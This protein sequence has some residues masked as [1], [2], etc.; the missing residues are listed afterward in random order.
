MPPA[1]QAHGF[2]ASPPAKA[3]QDIY[4]GLTVENVLKGN[5][6]NLARY[7][8]ARKREQVEQFTPTGLPVTTIING[9][10]QTTYYGSPIAIHGANG[11]TATGQAAFILPAYDSVSNRD[12]LDYQ[13]DYTFPKRIAV[14][15]GFQYESERGRL[16][17]SATSSN[18]II[19]RS[20]YL[21]TLQ[22]QCDVKH[23]LFYSACGAL[24]NNELYG[25][26]GQPRLGL[27]YDAV[28][29]G[30]HIFR[31]TLLRASAATGVQEPSTIA[32]LTSLYTRLQQTGNSA[33]I[34]LYK[35][36]PITAERSRTY[37]VGIDQ[38]IITQKLTLKAGYFHGQF[39]HQ[40]EFIGANGLNYFNILPP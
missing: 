15:F 40:L 39:S 26:A 4:S 34:A 2:P 9:T 13:S 16:L 22:V 5:W 6:H 14:L 24:E 35:V 31:G 33:G 20:N 28:R 32:Q 37:D 23:R 18:Q 25:I 3:D 12:V 1:S 10:P 36:T 17:N 29:P 19:K 8:I 21:Y 38:N 27:T 30:H 11:Y 7:G